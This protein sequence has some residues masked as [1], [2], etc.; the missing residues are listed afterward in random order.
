[1]EDIYRENIMDHYK[2]PR[3]FG[4]LENANIEFHDYNPLCGDE[5][6]VQLKTNGDEIK[7]IKFSGRGCALSMATASILTE[8]IKGKAIKDVEKLTNEDIFKMIG[9][10][11][12]PSRIK[13][14]LLSLSAI[15]K[16]VKLN[17]IK[18]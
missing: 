1:M 18:N 16:G 15:K 13:C 4:K 10:N 14:V 6:T 17:D 2:N 5:I 7:G 12:S 8:E 11:V 3:N 9:I